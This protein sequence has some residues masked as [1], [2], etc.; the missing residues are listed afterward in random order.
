MIRFNVQSNEVE[1]SVSEDNPEYSLND[2]IRNYNLLNGKPKINGVTLQGDLTLAELGIAEA[3]L[4][5]SAN[6]V[7]PAMVLDAL[8]SGQYVVLTTEQEFMGLPETFHLQMTVGG[9][10]SYA[11][12]TGVFEHEGL[13]FAVTLIGS[14]YSPEW[15]WN[16]TRLA[17]PEDIPTSSGSTPPM[18][19]NGSAGTMNGVY[20]LADHQHPSDLS[21]MAAASVV[22]YFSTSESYSIGEL[23]ISPHT[24]KLYRAIVNTTPAAS[25]RSDWWDE[26]ILI[27]EVQ[28]KLTAGD[29]ISLSENRVSVTGIVPKAALANGIPF[30]QV[31]S[32]STSTAFTATVPGITEYKDGVCVMLKNG[33]VT[34]AAGFTINVNGLGAKPAYNNMAAAT[35]ETTLF[36]VNYTMLFVYDE[37]R[38]EGGC[39]ILYRGYNANDNTIGYQLRTN[40]SSLPMDSVVYRYRLLFTSAD[41]EK[42]VPAN[43][44]TSTN[45]TASR[46]TIQTPINPFGRIVYYGTTTSVAAGSRPGVSYLW[47]QYG[48]TLGYSF[49]RTG[50]ALTL[51]SWK[52]VYIKC[53][54]QTDGSAIIDAD[55]P[56]VQALPTTNDGK[57]YIYLGIA[58]S[59]TQVEIV[60]EHPV[61]YHDGTRIRLWT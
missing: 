47:S 57:I 16:V 36:N 45:A 42:W 12:G 15:A 39:W 53:A 32:T 26:V 8:S 23:V 27:D 55:T 33:V 21:R 48:I 34:S 13:M 52:P 6:D 61:Y 11:L 18:D 44:S 29:N 59:A 41:N 54:P 49:N 22:P 60:P 31:D 37:D 25:I 35:A 28:R 40:L 14:I 19:G 43:N 50:A 38:V 9:D 58:Y 1:T 2:P 24:G 56:Y 5:G 3:P 20:S 7:T 46:T 30:G 4:I 17:V 51:T 10:H